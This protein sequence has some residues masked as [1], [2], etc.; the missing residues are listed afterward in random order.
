MCNDS[1]NKCGFNQEISNEEDLIKYKEYLE[2]ELE[3]VIKTLKDV[4]EETNKI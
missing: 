1:N 2:K 3:I 4:K